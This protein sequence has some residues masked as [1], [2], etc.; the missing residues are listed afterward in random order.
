MNAYK[1]GRL[2]LDRFFKFIEELFGDRFKKIDAKNIW[3]NLF[4]D[5]NQI[6][7]EEFTKKYGSEWKTN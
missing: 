3:N 5:V 7:G 4:G 6:S 2:R 1:K